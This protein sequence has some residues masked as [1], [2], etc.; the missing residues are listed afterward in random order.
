MGKGVLSPGKGGSALTPCKGG[1]MR[2]VVLE[3]VTGLSAQPQQ[4]DA[5]CVQSLLLP[6]SSFPLQAPFLSLS[7]RKRVCGKG[8]S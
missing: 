1:G 3:E 6:A 7:L 8:A 4:A 2:A 5:G